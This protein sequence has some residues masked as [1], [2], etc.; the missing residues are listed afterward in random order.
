MP[1]GCLDYVQ[2]CVEILLQMYA[3]CNVKINYKQA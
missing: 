2:H 1:Y 3:Y